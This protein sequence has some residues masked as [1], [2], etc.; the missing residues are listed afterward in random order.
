M[1]G[2]DALPSELGH[3]GDVVRG[4]LLVIGAAVAHH[5]QA[6]RAVRDL[7]GDVDV[8]RDRVDGVEEL[9]ER[10][11]VPPQTL[12]Q[13]GARNVLD[14]FHQLDQLVV[15]GVVHRREPDPT[16]AGDHRGHAV[17]RRRLQPLVPG[18]LAVVVRVDVD[19]ARDHEPAV[20]VDRATCVPVDGT[21]VDDHAVGDRHVGGA[22]WLA[23]AV[24]DG[25]TPDDQ[26]VVGHA[27]VSRHSTF[28]RDPDARERGA[29][30]TRR[31]DS[32]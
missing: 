19:D 4:G 11:P 32:P 23:G 26:V 22:C 6:Q 30:C 2:L 31:S 14:A 13:R 10:V 21:H 27:Q 25:T 9:A 20:G 7:H 12:V 28:D 24:D 5:V 8:V 15:V 18:G 16:V 29:S 3:R 1:P 17:P